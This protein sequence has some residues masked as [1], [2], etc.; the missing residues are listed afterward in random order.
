MD[1]GT[2]STALGM[3]LSKIANLYSYFEFLLD[4]DALNERE[5]NNFNSV[6][7]FA[8]SDDVDLRD[9]GNED[10]ATRIITNSLERLTSLLQKVYKRKSIILIDE[11]DVPLQKAQVRGYYDEMLTVIRG[12]FENTLKTNINLEK[13]F[14]TGCLRITHESIF[15]GV[16]NFVTRSVIDAPLSDFIGFTGEEVHKLLQQCNLGS[17]EDEVV[18]WYD[19]YKFSDSKLFCPWSILNFCSDGIYNLENNKDVILKNYWANS[20]SNDVIEM[21]IRSISADDS[22]RLQNL[23]DGK[24]EVIESSEFTTYP[25]IKGCNDIEIVLNLM[26]HTGYLTVDHIPERGKLAVKIPNQEILECFK[27]KVEN[28][29]S[30]KNSEWLNKAVQLREAFFARKPEVAQTIMIDMLRNFISIRNIAQESYY[31]AFL[32]G[33]LAIASGSGYNLLSDMESGDGYAD[34]RIENY[35]LETV[36]IIECKKTPDGELSSV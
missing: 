18:R 36:V 22:Q 10:R 28:I 34:L 33:V 3:L 1:G 24:A 9:P 32:S 30:K 13:S 27:D 12:L 25:D 29:F 31:H 14:V 17:Y 11:Y 26:L 35:T 5:K 23:L 16:N 7:N 20:S 2:F 4:S 21:C 19:G 15:T 8:Y 6:L